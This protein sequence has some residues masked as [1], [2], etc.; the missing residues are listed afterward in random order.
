MNARTISSSWPMYSWKKRGPFARP[1]I[2]LGPSYFH[3]PL[4]SFLIEP[5][6]SFAAATAS[7]GCEPAV[8]RQNGSP[9]SPATLAGTSS[10]VGEYSLLIPIGAKRMGA[11][12]VCPKS[13]AGRVR[14]SARSGAARAQ[15][16]ARTGHVARVGVDE[17][18]R[19]DAPAVERLAAHMSQIDELARGGM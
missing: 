4:L 17:H 8:E 12:S 6:S 13:S 1:D 15:R 18:A 11:G 14:A 3:T 2:P 19:D 7:I 5:P 16:A 9:S 10:P